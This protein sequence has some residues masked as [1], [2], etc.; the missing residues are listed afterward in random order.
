MFGLDWVAAGAGV[1]GCYLVGRGVRWGWLLFA[2][3]SALN[4][5]VGIHSGVIGM[6]CASGVYFFLEIK[7]YITHHK[8]SHKPGE[9]EEKPNDNS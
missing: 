2:C 9:P 3:A 8:K 4:V 7:G 1:L 6:A 5:A